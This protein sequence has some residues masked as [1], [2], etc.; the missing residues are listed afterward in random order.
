MEKHE[1]DEGRATTTTP[2]DD[3]RSEPEQRETSGNA[4]LIGDEE[5]TTA[6][7]MGLYER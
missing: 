7:L 4:M 6:R 3:R 5:R 2:T 1:V